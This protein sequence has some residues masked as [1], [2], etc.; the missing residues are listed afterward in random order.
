[1]LTLQVNIEQIEILNEFSIRCSQLC[2]FV[3]KRKKTHLNIQ[4]VNHTKRNSWNNYL[5]EILDE[6]IKLNIP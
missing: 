5:N 4:D 3:S 6:L 1:M 2:T